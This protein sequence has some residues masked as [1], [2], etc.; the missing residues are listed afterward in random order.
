VIRVIA[1]AQDVK[2]IEKESSIDEA[3]DRKK[4]RGFAMALNGPIS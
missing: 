4:W 3:Y 2:S 1:I